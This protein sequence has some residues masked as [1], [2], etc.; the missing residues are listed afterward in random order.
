MCDRT[1]LP[2]S[3]AAMRKTWTEQYNNVSFWSSA[4]EERPAGRDT[5]AQW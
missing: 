5:V 2:R 1:D 3:T 4:K